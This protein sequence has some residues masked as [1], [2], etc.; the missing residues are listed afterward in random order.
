VF[1]PHFFLEG[2]TLIIVLAGSGA[3]WYNS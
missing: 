1:I 2:E 3:T